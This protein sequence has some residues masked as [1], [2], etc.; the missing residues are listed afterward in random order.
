MEREIKYQAFKS[1]QEAME[2]LAESDHK[3]S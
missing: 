1:M 3:I 2:Q